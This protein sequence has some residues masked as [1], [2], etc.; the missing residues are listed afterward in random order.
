M[1]LLVNVPFTEETV[2]HAEDDES[3]NHLSVSWPQET[4]KPD[5]RR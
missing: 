4:E 1:L 3:I 5:M 2:L